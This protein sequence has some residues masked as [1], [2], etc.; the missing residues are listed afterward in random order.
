[1][2]IENVFKCILLSALALGLCGCATSSYVG[3][4]YNSSNMQ[5]VKTNEEFMF[6]VY[7]KS[8]DNTNVKIGIS[9]TTIPEIL[10]IYVQ[11]DNLS[12]ETPYI[13]KVDDLRVYAQDKE[14]KLIS[15]SSY[16]NIYQ[17]AEASSMAAMSSIAPTLQ[18]MTGMMTNYNEINQTMIQNANQESSS[19]AFSKMETIG[20]QISKHSIKYSSAISPRKSQYYYFFIENTDEPLLTV[21]YKTLNYQF[22][23]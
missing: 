20:N 4:D 3:E 17:A 10:A 14:V 11:I 16:L 21:K 6:D 1:M 5:T 9:K 19:S 18:N 12:Y 7:K 23:F 8:I 13:F 15:S 22:R 2:K